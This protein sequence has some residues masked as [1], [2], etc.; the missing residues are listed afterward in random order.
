MSDLCSFD[1]KT[2]APQ[3]AVKPTLVAELTDKLYGDNTYGDVGTAVNDNNN[4]HTTAEITAG[5]STLSTTTTT[6]LD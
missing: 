1:G 6:R 5:L 2:V 3:L 4:N